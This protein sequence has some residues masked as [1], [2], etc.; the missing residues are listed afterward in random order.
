M[1][2]P[3]IRTTTNTSPDS[4]PSAFWPEIEYISAGKI[5]ELV[6]GVKDQT[7]ACERRLAGFVAGEEGCGGR[8][9]VLFKEGEIV[10]SCWGRNDEGAWAG[11]GEEPDD[12]AEFGGE[13]GE[14]GEC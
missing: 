4:F 10:S 7:V 2:F 1:A 14:E 8:M 6:W 5:C 11:E 12:M 3:G 9:I 13:V